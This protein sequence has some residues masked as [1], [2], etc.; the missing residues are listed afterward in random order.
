M[1]LV[2]QVAFSTLTQLTFR[3][4]ELSLTL[5]FKNKDITS[6]K[7]YSQVSGLRTHQVGK[8]SRLAS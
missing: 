7:G 1:L 5:R 3:G 8:V 6:T 4:N 2:G